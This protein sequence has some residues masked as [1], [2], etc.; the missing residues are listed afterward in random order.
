MPPPP[1]PATA[2]P[3]PEQAPGGNERGADPAAPPGVLPN[4]GR[5]R[6]LRCLL[7]AAVVPAALAV[8]LWLRRGAGKPAPS[9]EPDPFPLPPI[10]ASP[11][12]NTGP[13]ARYVGSETCRTCHAGRHSSFRH[14]GM[15]R[16]LALVDVEREPPDA[17]FD[18]P[19]SKRRYRV[20]RK[21]RQ[22][23]HRETLLTEGPDEVLLSEY[24]VRY[25][26]GS[27]R[28]ART[29]LVEVDGFL[30]E[31]P[32]T[33][34][35]S[36]KAWGVSPGYDKPE[37][38][39][40]ARAVGEGCL[41][42][43]AGQSE[44][45]GQ[46][47]HRMRLGELALGC[48]RCHGPGS[49]HVERQAGTRPAARGRTSADDTIVNPAR[50]SRDL[51][52]AV[53]QQCHL[54]AVA[55]VPARG[56]KLADFRPGLPLQDFWHVYTREGVDETMKV[57]GHVEQMHQSR[58]YQG[59]QTLTCVTC[60]SPHAEPAP[61]Q[62]TA[63]YRSVCLDCH[64]PERCT[65][66]VRRRQ[67]ESPDNDCVHCHMPR[68][69]TDIPHLAFTH[70]RIG[71]HDRPPA[72]GQPAQAAG[73][74]PFFDLSHLSDPDRKRSLGLAY[75]AAALREKD[76][77]VEAWEQKQALGLLSEA[78]AAGLRGCDLDAALAR[79]CDGLGRKDEA[80]AYAESALR[81][82]DL[83]GQGRC[84]ALLILAQE[85]ARRQ[86]MA[87]ALDPLRELTRLR[88]HPLDWLLLATCQ[89]ALG[90]EAGAEE[91]L[92][93][94]VQ[95]NPRL[96]NVHRYLAEL[97]QRRGDAGRSAWHQRRAVP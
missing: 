17:A 20:Y 54:N 60:H 74:R 61:E 94:A 21:D 75:L 43:H 10:A 14:T 91:S 71:I 18:H 82:P 7:A 37:Q 59:S 53:C 76:A 36:L 73:L 86:H 79:V 92:A 51:A 87:S 70:H 2:A 95:I 1:T 62:R 25:V 26:V 13:A 49:L 48:E 69:G 4:R 9:P 72:A 83:A 77:G 5:R 45:V 88:R 96:W 27:G 6:I 97:Y 84:D 23:W 29:Y 52:E 32:V 22:L 34:Y 67:K 19:L 80:L 93:R 16:S 39:G 66:D 50:L 11:F 90:D 89:R 64:K 78:R 65:V 8:V 15:G 68:S 3:L 30:V 28:H 58:C 55:G 63:Y 41:F 38:L 57:T 35:P 33:W 31:S 47:L 12:L 44:P 81:D 85:R 46:S 40:F 42:C 24:P 56:R